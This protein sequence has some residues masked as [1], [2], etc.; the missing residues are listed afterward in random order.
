MKG[1]S[2]SR[3]IRSALSGFLSTMPRIVAEVFKFV[4]YVMTPSYRILVSAYNTCVC[5]RSLTSDTD[6]Q[7]GEM[8]E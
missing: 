2:V 1:A 4:A 8:L 6:V 3:T 7:I 5:G